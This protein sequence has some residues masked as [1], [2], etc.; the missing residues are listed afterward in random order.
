[1]AADE[2]AI[3][4]CVLD[5]FEG[6]FEADPERMRRALH[7]DLAKRSLGREGLDQLTASQMVDAT[8]AGSGRERDSGA[9]RIDVHV[10]EVYGDIATAVVNSNVYREYLHLVRTDG[11]WKIVNA[12]WAFTWCEKGAVRRASPM[13]CPSIASRRSP[14][15]PPVW[16]PLSESSA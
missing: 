16:K 4:R 2:D 14:A 6:W 15:L 11:A 10:V 3:V 12:L 5:Y 9:R 1:M 7:P 13:T 8:A